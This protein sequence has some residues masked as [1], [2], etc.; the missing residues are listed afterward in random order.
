MGSKKSASAL[1]R[2][3]YNIHTTLLATLLAN[4]LISLKGDYA[5]I[6]LVDKR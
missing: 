5:V 4:S 6:A 3:L 2:V 1:T